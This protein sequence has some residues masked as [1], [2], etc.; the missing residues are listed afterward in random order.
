M[1][2]SVLGC[3]PSH[4]AAASASSHSGAAVGASGC[5]RASSSATIAR[6]SAS[7]ASLSCVR[8]SAAIER[9]ER[10]RSGL[11]R[12]GEERL[13]RVALVVAKVVL[14]SMKTVQDT[15]GLVYQIFMQV[16]A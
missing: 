9:G 11:L 12:R 14:G 2:A 16:T 13:R 8:D 6:I 15:E 4:A 5:R 1:R 7:V 3:S 10:V